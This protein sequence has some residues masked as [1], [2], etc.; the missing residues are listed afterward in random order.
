MPES[1]QHDATPTTPP[2]AGR[3]PRAGAPGTH[4][5]A[6]PGP[7]AVLFEVAWEVCNQVGGIYQVLRSKVPAMAERWRDR[8]F[9]VGPWVESKASLE[10]DQTRPTG[11]LGRVID[12]LKDEGVIIRHG[13]WL[14]PGNPRA[15]LLEHRVDTKRLD[16]I[17]YTLWKDHGIES[18][19]GDALTDS[20]IVFGEAVRRLLHHVCAA[21]ASGGD[22]RIVAHFHEYLGALGL[23]MI[24]RDGL[25]IATV[26]TTHATLLGRY[27]ASNDEG[28]YDRLPRMDGWAEAERFNV[29]PQYSMERSCAHAAHVFTTV[30][31]ITAE[32]CGQLLGRAP[33]IVTPNGLNIKQFY[34]AHE[35][36]LLH[37]EYKDRIHQFTMG[38]FFPSYSFDLDKTLYVFTSGRFEPRN[39]GFDLCLEAMARLN[40]ELRVHEPGVTVV[41]FIITQRPVRSLNPVVLE[42]RGVLT[43][44]RGVCRRIADGLLEQLHR[45]GAAGERIHLDDLVDEYWRLRYKRTQFAL[46]TNRLPLITTHIVEDDAH[47]PVLNHI[48]HLGLIN[49]ADDPVKVVYHPEFI[50]PVNPLWG[51]EYEQFVRG[52]HLGLFPSLYEPWGYTPLECLALGVP[53]VS[54]DLAGFGR[55]VIEN[56]L[57]HEELG[58]TVLRRRGRSFHDSAADLTA[59]LLDYCRQRRRDRI[60]LRNTVERFSWEFDWGR[61]AEAYHRAH[62]LAMERLG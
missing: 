40:A 61:L 5:P 23:P 25:P 59:K 7:G 39:K 52:C 2:G 42:K 3:S 43:E 4:D 28:F 21:W 32:E 27:A 10:F 30:S 1:A 20:A 16:E 35:M 24:R 18:P 26:F 11:W 14:V 37:A 58:V 47:D 31:A 13:R 56:F 8:Y 17:K 12:A 45:R 54:S 15:L 53:A 19:A 9:V 48:R 57:G 49:R 62:D 36:Q 22:R 6:R 46:R 29:R 41:F 51:V 44:L 50:N 33:E 60:A 34:A 55:H 38:H